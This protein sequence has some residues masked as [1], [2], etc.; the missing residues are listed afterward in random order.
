MEAIS[1]AVAVAPSD[2]DLPGTGC[3]Q[4]GYQLLESKFDTDY[5][6]FGSSPK[7]PQPGGCSSTFS[8]LSHFSFPVL[9]PP[10]HHELCSAFVNLCIVVNVKS[11]EAWG[12]GSEK[13]FSSIENLV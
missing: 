6:G 1:K 9:V 2:P 7:F 3:I 12:R 5:G 10:I 11:R 13:W 8:S 4:R